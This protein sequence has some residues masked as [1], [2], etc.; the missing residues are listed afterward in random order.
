MAVVPGQDWNGKARGG[1]SRL[2]DPEAGHLCPRLRS[3]VSPDTHTHTCGDNGQGLL[4]WSSCALG[5]RFLLITLVSA[6][7]GASFLLLEFDCRGGG[8]LRAPLAESASEERLTPLLL[9]LPLPRQW[10]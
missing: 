9:P 6:G 8:W 7:E 3:R 2:S 4:S 10:F 1:T 5:Y